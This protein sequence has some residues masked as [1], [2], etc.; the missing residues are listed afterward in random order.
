M[1]GYSRTKYKIRIPL[2]KKIISIAVVNPGH[3]YGLLWVIA[4]DP[5]K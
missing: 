4:F 1:I 5:A 2:M 3:A